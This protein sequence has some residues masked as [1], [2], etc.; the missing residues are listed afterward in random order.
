MK[1]IIG[2]CPACTE[3][4]IYLSEEQYQCDR[5][6]FRLRKEI[7]RHMLTE[8]EIHAILSGK[9]TE[10]IS[11]IS[12]ACK[13]FRARLCIDPAVKKVKFLFDE[14][15]DE[16]NKEVQD[17][18]SQINEPAIPNVVHIRLEAE[19][20]GSSALEIRYG[21]WT[22][23]KSICFGNISSREAEC[24]AGISAINLITWQ[25][26]EYANLDISLSINNMELANYVLRELAP[27]SKRIRML[28]EHFLALLGKFR[29]WSASYDHKRRQRLEG[30]NCSQYPRG[31]FPWLT[32]EISEVDNKICIELPD[33]PDIITQFFACFTNVCT[34][35]SPNKILLPIEYWSKVD[36]WICSVRDVGI[37]ISANS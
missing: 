21:S 30:G 37:K 1:E 36:E 6:R 23:R 31:V 5:C 17:T 9:A 20:S 10:F 8:Q 19:T 15:K 14:K 27:R 22:T 11:F 4:T 7:S 34:S 35:D 26:K 32:T 16:Q 24:L 18:C 28:V 3:G 25:F 33:S 2:K 13:P 12:K 29:S